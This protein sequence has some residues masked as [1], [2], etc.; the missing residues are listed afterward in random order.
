MYVYFYLLFLPLNYTTIYSM[1]LGEQISLQAQAIQ[2]FGKNALAWT[3]E[4][5]DG[6]F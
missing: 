2:A 6:S 1:N 3:Y 5:K 4:S